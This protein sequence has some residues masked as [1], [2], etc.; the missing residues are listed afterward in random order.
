MNSGCA[1]LRSRSGAVTLPLSLLLGCAFVASIGAWSLLRRERKAEE[2]ELHLLNCIGYRAQLFRDLQN[3]IEETNDAIRTTRAAIAA[4]T[5]LPAALPELSAALLATV[6]LQDMDLTAYQFQSQTWWLARP[7]RG[8]ALHS[9]SHAPRFVPWRRPAP[10]PI[11]PR[12]LE[13]I[14]PGEGPHE[15]Q[16]K[17]ASGKIHR[18]AGARVLLDP[19]GDRWSSHWGGTARQP[20]TSIG[21]IPH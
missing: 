14:P 9:T 16:I 12:P 15:F 1:L 6:S 18:S 11:G 3:R 19:P 5:L 13:L 4:S 7:C 21:T 17:S 10:D 20:P 8:L 2:L